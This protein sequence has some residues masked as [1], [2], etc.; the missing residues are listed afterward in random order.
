M[1]ECCFFLRG[2]VYLGDASEECSFG[3]CDSLTCSQSEGGFLQLGNTSTLLLN[4]NS[5]VIGRENKYN[6]AQA[7]SRT[8]IE[9]VGIELNIEC[10]SRLNLIQALYAS[11]KNDFTSTSSDLFCKCI[12]EG[13]ILLLKHAPIQDSIVVY[14]VDAFGNNLRTLIA[15]VEY[16]INGQEIELI[17]AE[18]FEESGISI[19]AEYSFENDDMYELNFFDIAPKYKTIRFVGENVAENN[20]NVQFEIPRVLLNPIGSFDL[21]SKGEF[22]NLPLTGVVEESNNGWFKITRGANNGESTSTI[23]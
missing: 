12:N 6:R 3:E 8:N 17:N 2:K 18:S 9:G 14:L 16:K 13:E 7:R 10:V 15:D 5:Q 1:K 4:I 23:Y 22:F 20:E 11:E 19:L 21:I